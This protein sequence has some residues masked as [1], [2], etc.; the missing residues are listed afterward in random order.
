MT[1][2]QWNYFCQ[3]RERFL[4]RC[5]NWTK[6]YSDFLIPLQE[7]A[8][9]SDNVPDYNIENPIV[10]NTDLDKI[11]INSDINYVIVGDNP[12][13]EEQLN[14]NIRYLC[15]LSGK[16]AD[17]Y[18]KKHPELNSDFRKNV[19][20][21]NK[22]PI[23]TA[24]T[25]ELSYLLKHD[26]NL[27]KLFIESQEFMAEETVKLAQIFYCPLWIVGYSEIKEK[28]IFQRY[29]T[30]LE[31][32]YCQ[33]LYKDSYKKLFVYQHFSMN[34]FSIDLADFLKNNPQYNNLPLTDQL[35]LL[36]KLHKDQIFN[37]K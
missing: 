26:I 11:N 35:E 30:K 21:L 24:K 12:G 2:D 13:K 15:G 37:L 17:G 16:I 36:G 19:I 34:R 29:K 25:K 8:R 3:F 5:Q 22:T 33:D 20:I 6:L 9:K 1:I 23:H 14:V 10:Y 28:G 7:Q 31:E 32:L 27:Q 18:F 4:L